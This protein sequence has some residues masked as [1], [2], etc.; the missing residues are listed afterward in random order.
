MDLANF[1]AIKIRKKTVLNH[2]ILGMSMVFLSF[3]G[4]HFEGFD[5]HSRFKILELQWMR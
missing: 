2:W 4:L 1:M 5:A 3:C